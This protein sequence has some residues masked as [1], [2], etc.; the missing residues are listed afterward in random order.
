MVHAG[1]PTVSPGFTFFLS[2]L[3]RFVLIYLNTAVMVQWLS[4]PAESL[5][6][7]LHVLPPRRHWRAPRVASTHTESFFPQ[8]CSF[9]NRGMLS[10]D[11]ECCVL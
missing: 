4:Q 11:N 1:S 7:S 8:R 3:H 10:C 5:W 6:N 2:L 9:K